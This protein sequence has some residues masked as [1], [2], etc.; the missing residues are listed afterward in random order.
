M[1]YTGLSALIVED[2]DLAA[3][4]YAAMLEEIGFGNIE[5]ARDGLEAID[6]LENLKP[7]LILCD[8]TMPHLNGLELIA[9]IRSGLTAAAIDTPFIL[10]TGHADNAK[11][12][13][14]AWLSVQDFAMKPIGFN[15]LSAMIEHAITHRPP[16]NHALINAQSLADKISAARNAKS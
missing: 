16:T 2:I 7:D 15:H 5:A 6:I 14:A 1:D 9:A 13:A 8:F 12:R 10:M 11:I 4:T 3:S